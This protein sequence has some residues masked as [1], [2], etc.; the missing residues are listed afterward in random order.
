MVSESCP[1]GGAGE[2]HSLSVSKSVE[3]NLRESKISY[4][5]GD[6]GTCSGVISTWVGVRVVWGGVSIHDG[7]QIAWSDA[8]VVWGWVHLR[9][10]II[11]IWGDVS[12]HSGVRRVCGDPLT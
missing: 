3:L 7:V 2:P 1:C 6:V 8:V 9:W 4:V 11:L 5:W 10:N 12:V